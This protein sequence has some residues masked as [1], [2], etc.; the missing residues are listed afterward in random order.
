MTKSTE[1]GWYYQQVDLGFNYRMTELQAALGI[2]QMDR[3][4]EFITVRHN[5][6]ERYDLLL[7]SSIIKPHQDQ[8]SYSALHLYPIQINLDRVNKSRQQVFNELRKSGIGINVH[9][10][11]IHTQPYYQK[12]GHQKGDFPNA[13]KFY[14]RSLSLPLYF[15]MTHEQQDFIVKTLT[16]AIS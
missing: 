9:Y 8:D 16:N 4:N 2:S 3:L 5:L 10:I 11:P 6:Q 7:D 14:S 1:G 12:F 13:E 15:D